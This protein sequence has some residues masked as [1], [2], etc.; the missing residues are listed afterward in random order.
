MKE[1]VMNEAV[2]QL[3]AAYDAVPYESHAF[4]QTAPGHLAAIAYVF[5]LDRID[6]S[7]SRVLEIGCAAGG[8]LIPFALLH[9]QTHVV[10]VDLSSVQIE[11]GRRRVNQLGVPNLHL[12]QGDISAIDPAA[13]GVFDFIICHGVYSWVPPNVQEAILSACDTMMAPH[14]VAYISYNVYPGWKSKEIVRDAMLLR[15]GDRATPNEKLNYAVGMINFLEEVA[16][17]DSVMAKAVGDYKKVRSSV[18]DAYVLHEYLEPFNAPC[19]FLEFGKRTEPYRLTYL[20]DSALNTMFAK[21]YGEKI[22]VP[23]LRECG[24]SQVLVEQYLDFFCN[25]TFRQTLLVHGDR[26]PLVTYNPDRTRLKEMHFAASSLIV[27]DDVPLDD[28]P[29]RYASAGLSTKDPAIKAALSAFKARWPWTLSRQELLA[30][31][32]ARLD[33]AAVEPGAD[34]EERIDDLLELLV[35][36]GAAKFRLDSLSPMPTQNPLRLDDG[37]RRVI[38]LARDVGQKHIFNFWHE[39][40]WLTPV[41]LEI[42]PLLDGTHDRRVLIEQLLSRIR[43]GVVG[44]MRDGIQLSSEADLREA[45]AEYVNALPKRLTEMKLIRLDETVANASDQAVKLLS[46]RHRIDST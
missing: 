19:Y 31:V 42:L 17:A 37:V 27:E 7:N 16:P 35:V 25:R 28:S 15:G 5:G 36:S 11:E 8:N 26:A 24:H 39:T 46:G 45:A 34:L 20:A 29:Q 38:E 43:T 40:I 22:A 23:L 18:G 10:G 30:R 44:F 1:A 14:G 33:A 13:L 4:P 21:N 32:S 41:D 12:L 3:R 6:V 9:P 2:D